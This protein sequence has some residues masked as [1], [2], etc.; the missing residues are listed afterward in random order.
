MRDARHVKRHAGFDFVNARPIEP[1]TAAN[2]VGI[3]SCKYYSTAVAVAE[4]REVRV[5]LRTALL[6]FRLY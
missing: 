5:A 4:Q 2:H 1:I 3:H 6:A